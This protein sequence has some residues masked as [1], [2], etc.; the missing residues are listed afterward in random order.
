MTPS[1]KRPVSSLQMSSGN[2]QSITAVL[3]SV[4]QTTITI[5]QVHGHFISD[6]QVAT[7]REVLDNISLEQIGGISLQEE[8]SDTEATLRQERAKLAK[9]IKT[10][11]LRLKQ[12][13]S[14]KAVDLNLQLGKLLSKRAKIDRALKEYE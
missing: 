14:G 2:F 12:S 6:T 1:Y 3:N 4:Q 5:G 13:S 8:S 10:I 7:L 9:E 11:D